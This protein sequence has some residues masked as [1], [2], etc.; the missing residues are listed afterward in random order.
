MCP[1]YDGCAQNVMC[2]EMWL[3][4]DV[5]G[6]AEDTEEKGEVFKAEMLT[7]HEAESIIL[8]H[9]GQEK[10]E[11]QA[12][13]ELTELILLLTA[14]QDQR[15]NDYK[16]RLTEEMADSIIMIEQMKIANGITDD[17]ITAVIVYKLRRTLERIDKGIENVPRG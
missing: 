10:Q 13:Q 3:K 11:I 6:D 8:H 9:Y 16:K 15:G 17:D 4:Q 1:I 5:S 14:R 2:V 12:V 7:Q